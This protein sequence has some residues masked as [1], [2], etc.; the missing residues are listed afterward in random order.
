M[1]N[2]LVAI[3]GP[4][5]RTEDSEAM[6]S[7]DTTERNGQADIDY[8]ILSHNIS[9]DVAVVIHNVT[10]WWRFHFNLREQR[11]RVW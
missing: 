4:R 11:E 6:I 7:S 9:V 2:W 8:N 1:A 10:P 3:L 5:G